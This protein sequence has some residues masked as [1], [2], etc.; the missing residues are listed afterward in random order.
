MTAFS[1]PRTNQ[2]EWSMTRTLRVLGLATALVT[3]VAG[4]SFAAAGGGGSLGSQNATES[5]LN[6]GG[7]NQMVSKPANPGAQ[8]VPGTS[9]YG[10]SGNSTT[11]TYRGAVNSPTTPDANH[12]AM[13]TTP[14]GGG[15]GGGNGGSSGH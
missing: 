1:C 13:G 11:Q 3:G 8:A 2:G 14:S 15:A 6:A 5:Q 12:P 4:A 7:Q 10:M 9:T